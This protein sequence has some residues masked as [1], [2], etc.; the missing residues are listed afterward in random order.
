[1]CAQDLATNKTVCV[2]TLVKATTSKV[3]GDWENKQTD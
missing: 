2:S 1:M 3:E